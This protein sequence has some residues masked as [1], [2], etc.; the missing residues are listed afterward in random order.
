MRHIVLAAFA[1]VVM[2]VALMTIHD[3]PTPVT[4]IPS[5]GP[6][7]LVEYTSTFAGRR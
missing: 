3:Q 7:S 1:L 2:V 4:P 5:N 6:A